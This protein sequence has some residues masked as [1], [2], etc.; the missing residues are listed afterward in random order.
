VTGAGTSPTAPMRAV[1]YERYGSPDQLRLDEVDR[2]RAVR[3]EVVVR[4]R[5]VS[6]NASDWETLRGKPAY[7]RIGGLTKPRFRTLGSDIAGVVEAAGPDVTRLRPGDEVF[8]DN[9]ERMGGFAEY[10]RAREKALAVK[11]PGLS[12]EDAAAI[13]QSGVIA[14]QG[15]RGVRPGQRV[16][17]NGAGGGAGSF[18]V[19]LAK[20]AG[21]EVT[22]VDR[23]EKL[24]FVRGLGADHVV[25]YTRDDFT[26]T[27]ER[28]DLVLDVTAH[29]SVFAYRRAVAP[30]GRYYCVGGSVPTLL[31]VLFLGP[32][33]G[34]GR[35]LRVLAVRQRIDDLDTLAALCLA[36]TVVPAIDRRY[37][38]ADVPE[39]MRHLG[40]GHA[41]GKLVVLP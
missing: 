7:A 10:A 9:L 16:L 18:A 21:A 32:V 27:G 31:Q 15:T 24:D 11:P 34:G 2:P 4:V 40:A 26:R 39:A 38:L 5:A 33:V 28:Y 30:G 8:G 20:L 13:P 19:Q 23:G 1:V 14:L 29:R 3:D 41:R 17:V 22:G 25:D 37:A 6:L 36:G 35:R 12:F